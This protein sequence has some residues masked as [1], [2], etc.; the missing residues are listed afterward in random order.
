MCV[1]VCVCVLNW[2]QKHKVKVQTTWY[3][4]HG[5]VRPEITEYVFKTRS[6]QNWSTNRKRMYRRREKKFDFTTTVKHRNVYTFSRMFNHNFTTNI[7]LLY[8]LPTSQSFTLKYV[9]IQ[10]RV[11]HLFYILQR[12]QSHVLSIYYYGQLCFHFSI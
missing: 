5:L 2:L 1:C 7:I 3:F 8:P 4:L 11:I 9:L 12:I 6:V 10:K